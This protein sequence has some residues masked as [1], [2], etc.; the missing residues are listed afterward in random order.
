MVFTRNI[1]GN[2][3]AY[4]SQRIEGRVVS[5][6]LGRADGQEPYARAFKLAEREDR[7]KPSEESLEQLARELRH[8]RDEGRGAGDG[9]GK[10]I[11]KVTI[12]PNENV[13][14]QKLHYAAIA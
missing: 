13:A 6:Y 4:R 1:K 9:E 7:E 11:E 14:L 8:G 5:I 12:Q 3:Y 2:V 10:P